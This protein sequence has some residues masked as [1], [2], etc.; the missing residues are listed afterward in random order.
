MVA[1]I[2]RNAATPTDV[3]TQIMSIEKEKSH[4]ESEEYED[5]PEED[6]D[7]EQDG[8]QDEEGGPICYV[9]KSSSEGGWKLKGKP[10]GER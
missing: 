3:D 2:V 8:Y 9:G 6:H 7:S 4:G 1:T 10:N 5:K